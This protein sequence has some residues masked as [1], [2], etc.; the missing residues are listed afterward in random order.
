MQS[1]LHDPSSNREV[2]FKNTNMVLSESDSEDNS[3]W[4]LVMD[5][6]NSLVLFPKNPVQHDT[7]WYENNNEII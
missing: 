3:K 4:I 1:H 7:H 6:S 2:G 5:T